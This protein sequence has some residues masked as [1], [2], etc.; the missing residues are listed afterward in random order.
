VKSSCPTRAS[1]PFLLPEYSMPSRPGKHHHYHLFLYVWLF[2]KS[3]YL[4][5]DLQP[6][7]PEAHLE[8]LLDLKLLVQCLEQDS[9]SMNA[10]WILSQDGGSLHP[11]GPFYMAGTGLSSCLTMHTR[12]WLLCFDFAYPHCTDEGTQDRRMRHHTWRH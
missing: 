11:L 6:R 2:N 4:S 3:L 9:C 7:K 5:L 8:N 12:R 10:D 1:L